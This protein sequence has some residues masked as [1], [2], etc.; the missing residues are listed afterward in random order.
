MDDN[1]SVEAFNIKIVRDNVLKRFPLLG[2]TLSHLKDEATLKISTSATTGDKILYNPEF[3]ACLN[4]DE[5]VSVYTHEV[6][7]VAFNHIMRS[8]DKQ[9]IQWNIA[10]DAV[11]NQI[12]KKEG[13]PILEGTVDMP[14][15]LNK[16]ADEVYDYLINKEK[17]KGNKDNNQSQQNTSSSE[18]SQNQSQEKQEHE[19]HGVWQEVIEQK[20]R[21]EQEAKQSQKNTNKLIN[22]IKQIFSDNSL[23]E[24]EKEQCQVS[25]KD[26]LDKNEALYQENIKNHKQKIE[27]YRDKLYS[28]ISAIN[29]SQPLILDSIGVPE[30]T[31]TNWKKLLKKTVME[32]ESRWSY[33]RSNSENDYMA[34]VED[35]EDENKSQT[36]VML[37]VSGSVDIDLL[38]EF[39]RQLKPL[40]KTTEMKVGCF[41][42]QST[43]F[44]LIKTEKDINN[45]RVCIGGGTSLDVAVRAFSKGQN[46]NH[47]VFTDGRG[48]M[49]SNNLKHINPIWVIYDNNCFV[50]PFGKVIYASRMEIMQNLISNNGLLRKKMIQR[51]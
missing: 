46:V 32:E 37:D 9:S 1:T 39:L 2:A 14:E 22:K 31:V 8:K 45:F 28:S 50:P 23:S 19:S 25:E 15:A 4:D 24:N 42:T 26:F 49:P 3:M 34:R 48:T 7:H 6:M 17:N 12:L 47:I 51:Q 43:A 33:R 41:N 16:S 11:I 27:Q 36:E 20:N 30:K 13:L 21:K 10:T 38:R 40:L 5:Q 29:E 35:L 18:N 44:T